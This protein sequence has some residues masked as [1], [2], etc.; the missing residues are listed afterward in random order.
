MDIFTTA[1][2][3]GA[4]I[5][6]LIAASLF[7]AYVLRGRTLP[8]ILP[9]A[10]GYLLGQGGL[11]L[12]DAPVPSRA[13]RIA[14]GIGAGWVAVSASSSA[15]A[16]FRRS[17]SRS[18]A[19]WGAGF[20]L[21]GPSCL[22]GAFSPIVASVAGAQGLSLASI[23]LI[24]GA[25]IVADPSRF[26]SSSVDSH[27]TS[28]TMREAVRTSDAFLACSLLA[29]PAYWAFARTLSSGEGVV[30]DTVVASIGVSFG[31]GGGVG[32]LGMFLLRVVKGNLAVAALIFAVVVLGSI[33]AEPLA[34]SSVATGFL[35]GAIMGQEER[36]RE[37]F[38]IV[39]RRLERPFAF[40]MLLAAGAAAPRWSG[41]AM[42]ALIVL[43]V[44][45][46]RFVLGSLEDGIASVVPTVGSG[47]RIA[48]I[49][50]VPAALSAA[51]IA[52]SLTL[53]QR[54]SAASVEEVAGQTAAEILLF[55]MGS[56]SPVAPFLLALG[57]GD[58]FWRRALAWKLR[59]ATEK[60][61]PSDSERHRHGARGHGQH[62]RHRHHDH[63][64]HH[65]EE[66]D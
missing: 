59:T 10:A 61:S 26:R 16:T 63:H 57:I 56:L 13:L 29:W 46:G 6:A 31:I 7:S 55:A 2:G 17:A 38:Y 41:V 37:T 53:P 44:L 49:V 66:E 51:M 22:A 36:A 23:S 45:V 32:L 54:L 39:A 35:A 18:A 21:I 4:A 34:A 50:S 9:L 42:P 47:R 1:T 64:H 5:A 33:V 60:P 20:A 65:R 28:H 25:A 15:A 3:L 52:E 14:L 48:W 24:V 30:A 40:L 62:G 8:V 58:L 27:L 12:L 19:W 43:V 11:D